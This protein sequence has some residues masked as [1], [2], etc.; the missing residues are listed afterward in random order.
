MKNVVVRIGGGLGNQMF[1]Y[2]YGRHLSDLTGRKLWL[3]KN[4]FFI[5]RFFKLQWRRVYGLGV[6]AG[7]SQ[8][9][10]LGIFRR[11]FYL[12]LWI[13]YKKLGQ[14][15]YRRVLQFFS[16]RWID[17]QAPETFDPEFVS[18]K[19]KDERGT[20]FASGIHC[21]IPLLPARDTLRREFAFVHE[22]TGKNAET[23]KDILTADKSSIS[24]H[25]RRT[26]YIGGNVALGLD[27]YQNAMAFMSD[28]IQNPR[29]FFFSDD[30]AWCKNTFSTVSNATFIEGNFNAPAE[31]LRLMS[32]CAH[33]IIA[34][35]TFSWWGAYL[36]CE[37]GLTLYPHP[38]FGDAP[39]PQTLIP[40]EWQ[41]VSHA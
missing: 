22:P 31:D 1:Q 28:R 34:N 9:P 23:M 36:S 13:V 4:E 29:W 20:I 14:N 5:S 7:P 32:A 24:V 35:S 10:A 21:H 17:S 25:I 18:P 19:L 8:T 15:A 33:H 16:I 40:A 30:V 37:D 12:F 2:A 3:D 41:P 6:F 38:W 39:A 26:D 11:P 27:Y